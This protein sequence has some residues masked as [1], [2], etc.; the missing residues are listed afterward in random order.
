MNMLG[1]LKHYLSAQV[2]NEVN[3]LVFKRLLSLLLVLV[4]RIYIRILLSFFIVVF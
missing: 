1:F 3:T 2:A 4:H